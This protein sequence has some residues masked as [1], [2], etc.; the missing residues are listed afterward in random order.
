MK[1]I[2][3]E[4]QYDSLF[5]RISNSLKRRISRD[6]LDIIGDLIWKYA[7]EFDDPTITNPQ[8]FVDIVIDETMYDFITTNK[9]ADYSEDLHSKLY[10]VWLELTPIIKEQYEH[11]LTVYYLTA[12]SKQMTMDQLEDIIKKFK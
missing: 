11:Q 9:L 2:I 12:I 8:E 7:Y 10:D 4:S 6:D 1:T 3:T 5:G